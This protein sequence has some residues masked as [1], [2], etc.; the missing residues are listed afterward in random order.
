MSVHISVDMQTDY[1]HRNRKGGVLPYVSYIY[2]YVP[3]KMWQNVPGGVR[4]EI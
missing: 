2:S 4:H 1:R 3:G